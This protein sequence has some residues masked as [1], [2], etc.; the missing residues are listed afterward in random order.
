MLVSCG[1]NRVDPAATRT[2]G[3]SLG[4]R[5]PDG[6]SAPTAL[7]AGTE[8]RAPYVLV[9]DDGWP[10][11]DRAPD[12]L[13]L[14]VRQVSPSKVVFSARVVRHGEPGVTP[15]Y[16][17]VFT[18]PTVGIYDIDGPTLAGGHRLQVAEVSSTTLVQIGD[19]MPALDTPTIGNDLGVSP[20][21]TRSGG[22]C[23]LHTL[24]LTQA[25]ARPGPTALLVSTP[26][27]C[28]MDVCGPALEVLV[29][30]A[31][32]LS[33]QWSVVHAE[34]YMNPVNGDFTLTPVVEAYGLSF[35]PSLVVANRSGEITGVVHFT[36]DKTEVVGALLSAS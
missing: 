3:L 24:T 9:G 7:V 23:P 18:P 34:V 12:A 4:A 22:A 2:G 26:R 20:I 10:V 17:L 1:T 19:Q 30:Q 28:Q 5:F 25:L 15:Y 6:F 29:S 8:Q 16:P 13:D 32:S 36:M 33:D 35:E 11:V 31:A 21:C 14:I 27:F